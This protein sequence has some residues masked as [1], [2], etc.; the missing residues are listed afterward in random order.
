MTNVNHEV[1]HEL[2]RIVLNAKY[3]TGYELWNCYMADCPHA[4]GGYENE[5]GFGPVQAA[6][7]MAAEDAGLEHCE[8]KALRKGLKKLIKKLRRKN[9]DTVTIIEVCDC[10]HYADLEAHTLEA[11]IAECQAS[12]QWS[13]DSVALYDAMGERMAI[14]PVTVGAADC[15][16]I[17][18]D[19]K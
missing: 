8:G 16:V 1:I 9:A 19:R 15:P 4:E 11:A 3:Y 14:V 10:G 13:S 7:Y 17:D 5:Y 6:A 18:T 12:T 2:E